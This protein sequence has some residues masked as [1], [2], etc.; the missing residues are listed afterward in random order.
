LLNNFFFEYIFLNTTVHKERHLFDVIIINPFG[1]T[2][3]HVS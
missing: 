3:T 2:G 1:T